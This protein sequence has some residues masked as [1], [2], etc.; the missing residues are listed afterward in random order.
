MARDDG[1]RLER[2]HVLLYA[3]D[4]EQARA[5]WGDNPGLSTALRAI[6][7]SFLRNLE[8]KMEQNTQ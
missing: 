8:A 3:K 5:L 6:V 2:V 7:R 1:E 4:I